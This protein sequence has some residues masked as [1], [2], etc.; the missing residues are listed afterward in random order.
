MNDLGLLC[1][2]GLFMTAAGL[3]CILTVTNHKTDIFIRQCKKYT[4]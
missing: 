3:V 4:R 1:V 2:F